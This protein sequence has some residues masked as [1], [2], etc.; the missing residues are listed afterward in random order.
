MHQGHID[1][2]QTEETSTGISPIHKVHVLCQHEQQSD[3]C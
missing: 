2:I 1:H 3:K